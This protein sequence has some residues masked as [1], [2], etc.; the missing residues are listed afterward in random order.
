MAFPALGSL[1]SHLVQHILQIDMS[2]VRSPTSILQCFL[3]SLLMNW[4]YLWVG[5]SRHNWV[6]S[7]L[8]QTLHSVRFLLPIQFLILDVIYIRIVVG[9]APDRQVSSWLPPTLPCLQFPCKLTDNISEQPKGRKYKK[10][11]KDIKKGRGSRTNLQKFLIIKT[12]TLVFNFFFTMISVSLTSSTFD[13][14]F[15]FFCCVSS[16]S[17]LFNEFCRSLLCFFFS[18]F[19]CNRSYKTKNKRIVFS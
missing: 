6:T 18:I 2:G 16:L 14:L 10:H 1:C 12:Y 7:Y 11:F 3:S 5:S 8:S 15:F 17:T 4:T 19:L 9:R 13:F